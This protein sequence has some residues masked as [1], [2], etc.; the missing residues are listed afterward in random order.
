M[1]LIPLMITAWVDNAYRDIEVLINPN[2][3][4]S[5]EKDYKN[6]GYYLLYLSDGRVLKLTDLQYQEQF[7]RD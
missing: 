7:V 2:A 1:N 4:V 5:L 6:D 3:V